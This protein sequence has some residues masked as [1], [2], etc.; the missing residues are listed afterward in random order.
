MKTVAYSYDVL[1]RWVLPAAFRPSDLT[2]LVLALPAATNGPVPGASGVRSPR[3]ALPRSGGG[4]R[5]TTT[6]WSSCSTSSTDR[7]FM[8]SRSYFIEGLFTF[9]VLRS[10]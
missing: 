1:P 2:G 4:R 3:G 8:H 9:T 5:R 7:P 6:S 10:T